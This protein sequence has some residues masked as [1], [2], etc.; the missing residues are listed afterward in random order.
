MMTAGRYYKHGFVLWV[1]LFAVGCGSSLDLDRLSSGDIERVKKLL[2]KLSPVIEHTREQGQLATLTL[3]ELYAGLDEDERGLLRSFESL[4]AKD[5]N[6]WIP[7]RG[8]GSCAEEL[9]VI[10]GQMVKGKEGVKELPPQFLP[11]RV[12]ASYVRM[13]EVMRKDIGR[14]LYV[15]SGYRSS[16]YQLY[17]FVSYLGEHD[18]SVRETARFVALP[19]YSEHGDPEHQAIDFVNE[20]GI[21]GQDNVRDFEELA[22]YKWLL[23]NAG[24]FGFVLSYPRGSKEGVSFEPWHWRHEKRIASK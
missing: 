22:E 16:A 1:V 19:G 20:E 13:M 4:D 15:E 3:D 24:K 8:M 7:Y 6:V 9:V 11:R 18:Y 14:G 21:N 17:L 10:K 12:Y 23:V 5:L 2:G